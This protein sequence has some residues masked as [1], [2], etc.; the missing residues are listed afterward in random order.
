MTTTY[1]DVPLPAGAHTLSTWADWDNLYRLVWT[2]THQVEGTQVVLS[3]CAPQLPNGT[4]VTR[5]ELADESAAV[6]V[7]EIRDGATWE[8]L[9]VTVAGARRLAQALTTIA[10]QLDGWVA[11]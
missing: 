1:P 8:R 7:D 5:G 4:I 3:A 6:M 11:R 2:K 9:S 10:D